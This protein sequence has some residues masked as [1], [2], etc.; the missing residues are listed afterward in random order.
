MSEL[1]HIHT[2]EVANEKLLDEL[3]IVAARF[4]IET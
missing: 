3:V 4:V 2:S 1:F